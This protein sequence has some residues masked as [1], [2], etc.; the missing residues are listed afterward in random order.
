MN[1]DNV[2]IPVTL[3]RQEADEVSEAANKQGVSTP[4]FLGYCVRAIAFG[5]IHAMRML[6][7]QGQSGT[8]DKRD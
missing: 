6:P 1:D 5:V 8:S 2:Q 4:D 3:T 7:L